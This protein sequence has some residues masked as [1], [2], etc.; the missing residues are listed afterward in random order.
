M[1]RT[2]RRSL[3]GDHGPLGPSAVAYSRSQGSAVIPFDRAGEAQVDQ[4]LRVALDRGVALPSGFEFDAIQIFYAHSG[5]IDELR[6]AGF[7]L[8]GRPW[9]AA[10]RTPL[11]RWTDHGAELLEA[12]SGRRHFSAV[13]LD[14]GHADIPTE[15]GPLMLALLWDVTGMADEESSGE[16]KYLNTSS[17]AVYQAVRDL[18]SRAAFGA[19]AAIP[20]PTAALRTRD[21]VG[22]VSLVPPSFETGSGFGLLAEQM[23]EKSRALSDLDA[24]VLDALLHCWMA[25]ARSDDQDVVVAVDEIL[26]LRGLQPKRNSRG[27]GTGYH[28]KQRRQVVESL[29]RL[30]TLWLDLVETS[31]RKG[32]PPR[33]IRS[34]ALL[35]TDQMGRLGQDGSLDV[36]RVVFRPGRMF[37]R[38]LSGPGRRVAKLPRKALE[39]DPYRFAVEKR[40]VRYLS[41]QWRIRAYEGNYLQPYRVETLLAAIGLEIDSR[42]PTKLRDRF[43]AALDRLQEDRVLAQWQ[44]EEWS[45]PTTLRRGWWRVWLEAKIVLEPPFEIVESYRPLTSGPRR[46][47]ARRSLEQ[48]GS[49]SRSATERGPQ[50]LALRLREKRKELGWSQLQLAERLDLSRSYVSALEAG[51]RPSPKVLRQIETWLFESI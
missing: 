17:A 7:D 38:L 25:G 5:Q 26:E 46:G 10:G 6:V 40:L 4:M 42:R 43:E 32:E 50:Q 28:P 36:E 23:W 3:V 33:A 8:A 20:W 21:T 19:D 24:D 41:W 30:Q 49:G 1:K 35:L 11:L 18:I 13:V 14:D 16:G 12:D 2:R 29:L 37:G 51:R 47:S 31:T 48:I 22:E 34:R 15:H 45:E 39:Y 27:Y 44:Y 9:Q